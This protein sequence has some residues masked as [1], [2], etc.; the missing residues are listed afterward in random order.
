M[1]TTCFIEDS[2]EIPNLKDFRPFL[3]KNKTK[4]KTR[5][6]KK[7]KQQQLIGCMPS[8][9]HGGI[10]IDNFGCLHQDS[11]NPEINKFVTQV[12]QNGH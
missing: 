7:K 6:K 5:Q 9:Q 2:H 11:Q 12:L 8:F 4:N 3:K 10:L 1:W